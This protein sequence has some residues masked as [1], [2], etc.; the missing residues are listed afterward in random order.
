MNTR[1]AYIS[2]HKIEEVR[3]ANDIVDVVSDYVQLKKSGSNLFGLC[4]F[5]SEKTPSFSV[6]PSMGIFKC[7]G[8]GVGGDV[9][10]FVIGVEHVTFPEA[11]RLLA[12]RAGIE[13]PEEGAATEGS[14]ETERIHHALRHAARFFYRTLTDTDAGQ[15]ALEY[16]LNRGITPASIKHFGLGYAPDGWEAL[17]QDAER[18][19][20]DAATLDRAGLVVPRKSGEGHYDRFRDRIMFPIF[21]QVGKVV[22]FGGRLLNENSEQPKYIN[23]PETPVY[24]KSQVLYGLYQ[25][26]RA[27]R[28]SKEI[29]VVEGY[30]DVVALHQHGFENAVAACGTSLTPDHLRLIGR[31]ADAV[32]ILNDGDTAGDAS[33]LRSL[34]L[35]LKQKLTPYVIEL[36]ENE[37]PAS[38]AESRSRDELERYLNNPKYRWTFVQ[39]LLIRAQ[40]EG[41]LEQ[42]ENERTAFEGVL[43]RIAAIDSR[44]DQETYL[45][46][47]AEALGKPIIHLHE[48]LGRIRARVKRSAGRERREHPPAAE[49]PPMHGAPAVQARSEK[50]GQNEDRPSPQV[51][52]EERILIRLMLEG[53]APMVEFVLGNMAMDEFS[54]G[55]VRSIVVRIIEQ[56]EQEAI[57]S[58]PFVEGAFGAD[59]QAL[60]AG[61]LVD[62]HV[63]SANWELRKNISVPKMNEEPLEAAASAMTL[64][65]LDRVQESMMRTK[66]RH[67]HRVE[68]GEDVRSEL[69]ELIGLRKLLGQIERREFLDWNEA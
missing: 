54:D 45:H 19:H 40:S 3:S 18:N 60:V 34:D 64:L 68:R 4:P 43:E 39:Y 17:L 44:F 29:Y 69:E 38:L 26:R 30:T 25:A 55:L 46:Q 2:E 10:Q 50:R 8:C 61:L 33:N 53:G 20:I 47:M 7:F 15:P 24:H 67:D 59:V 37:D 51:L 5:H 11:V 36:P 65:K 1:S 13:L 6:N 52:P 66:H 21:S 57:D 23:T 22:G 32:I 28:E 12:D 62:R 58:R 42:V 35:A 41:M 56:Y 48:E 63:P 31:Y 49:Q 9:F 16:I 14:S 27:V